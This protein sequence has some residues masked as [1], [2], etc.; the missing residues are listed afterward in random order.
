MRPEHVANRQEAAR[1]ATLSRRS[2][3]C[4]GALW[5]G[6]G[7]ALAQKATDVLAPE[8]AQVLGAQPR[9]QGSAR[10]RMF[11]LSIY[12]AKLWVGQSFDGTRF[13]AYPLALELTYARS[14]KGPAIAERSLEEIRRGGV[15]ADA[16]AQRW[17]AFMTQAFP[18]VKSGDRLVGLWEPSE[19]R[20]TFI[21]NGKRGP[22]LNDMV[23]G[24]RFFG[25]WLA[26]HSSQPEMRLTLLGRGGS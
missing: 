22:V 24:R 10:L 19:N 1:S 26:E 25:I 16:D 4:A 9:L 13:E 14:L 6:V 17:L 5:V 20:T 7:A 8:L 3:L 18:D 21:V 2:L 15:I 12:D 23:F 11:G